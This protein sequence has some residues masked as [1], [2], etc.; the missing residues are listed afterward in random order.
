MPAPRLQWG[1]RH[2][3]T[4]GNLIR[5]CIFPRKASAGSLQVLFCLLLL[6]AASFAS[7]SAP[8]AVVKVGEIYS[9]QGHIDYLLDNPEI[10]REGLLAGTY[11]NEFHRYEDKPVNFGVASYWLRM[12]ITNGSDRNQ[13]VLSAN[14]MLFTDVELLYNGN[15]RQMTTEVKPVN[16]LAGLLH[17]HARSEWPFHDIAFPVAMDP[18]ESKTF[19]LRLNTPY[20]L[21]LDPYVA[22]EMAYSTHQAHQVSWGYPIAGMMLGVLL[23]VSMIALYVRELSEVR[24]CVGFV[25]ISLV[26]LLLGR[27]YL[28]SLI[29]ENAWLHTHIYSLAFS[30]FAYTYISFSRRLFKTSEDFPLVNR[31]LQLA[32]YLYGMLFVACL[33]ITP[34]SSAKI[35]GA[36][37]FALVIVLCIISVYIWANSKRKLSVYILGTLM[38]LI[39]CILADAE[40]YGLLNMGGLAREAYESGLC[41]QAILFSLALAE[42]ISDYQIKKTQ[43]AISHAAGNAEDKTK[44][45]FLAK[46]NQELRAPMQDMLNTMQQLDRTILNDEQQYYTQTLRNAGNMLM[47]VI[48]DVLDYSSIITGKLQLKNSDFNLIEMLTDIES[49]FK[50]AARQKKLQLHFSINSNNHAYLHGDAT[51]LRQIIIN[52][53]SNAIKFTDAGSVNVRVRLDKHHDHALLLHCEV[54]DT[55]IGISDKDMQN[56]FSQHVKKDGDRSQGGSGLGLIICKKL[57]GI[58][59]GDIRVESAPGY[60]SLFVF[61]IPV[62]S[63]NKNG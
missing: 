25:L 14:N 62:T 3:R 15:N 19:Y 1:S 42:R 8:T 38:F 9:L 60:G 40:S 5:M 24:H 45:T 35:V 17:P 53:I 2:F 33:F 43:I 46:M 49:M 4:C 56:I 54:E 50:V 26:V 30:A 52:I 44:S 31:L 6:T 13:L 21:L 37:A 12:Q 36:L 39:S 55:G 11:D 47:G 48:D 23:Y 59:G 10:S 16:R 7:A 18:G 22:D 51:R 20:F 27:G 29:P 61:Q 57:V 41:L 28:L 58:M 32:E 34:N 63:A